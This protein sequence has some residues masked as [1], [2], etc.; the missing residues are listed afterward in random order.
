MI[1]EAAMDQILVSCLMI[2]QPAPERL[3]RARQ[4]LGAYLA[5]THPRKEL[6][7][8][9]EPKGLD[10][11]GAVLVDHIA[12]LRRPDIR[13]V[14][15]L[16]AAALGALRNRSLDYAAGDIVC[17][18]DDDDLC[19]P[20]RLRRQLA[21][22]LA[23]DFE[24]VYLQEVMQFFPAS[25]AIYWTNWRA[26]EAMAHPGTLM[27]RGGMPV[28]YVEAGAAAS[29][30]EDLDLA[31]RLQARGHVGYLA[32]QAPL[33]IYVSHGANSWSQD[34]HRMLISELAI[35]KGLLTRREPE[36]RRGLA[37]FDF[38]VDD[39][40]VR[41]SNGEAFRIAR[42]SAPTSLTS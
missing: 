33:F 5:Q 40:S 16:G 19:H 15:G 39:V 11:D 18:W 8:V 41:G 29:L 22:L 35:S 10:G 30:G 20:D 1:S 12:D 3:A 38:G 28:R 7:V 34:H 27:M 26:T 4:S 24:A 14:T 2:T 36:I 9:I 21:L 31:R 32:G 23:G 6:V 25:R 17:Q 13:V 37:A 42:G